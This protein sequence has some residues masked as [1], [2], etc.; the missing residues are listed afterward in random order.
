MDKIE[1][2]WKKLS[3]DGYGAAIN[4]MN[5]AIKVIDEKFGKGYAAKN[6]KL[7]GDFMKAAALDAQGMYIAK[8]IQNLAT[9]E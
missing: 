1:A 9:K 6:P 5:E 3:D 7:V 2:N 4:Y 8:A